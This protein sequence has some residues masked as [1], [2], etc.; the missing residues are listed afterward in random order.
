METAAPGPNPIEL[1][2][3]VGMADATT[4]DRGGARDAAPDP[5]TSEADG[6]LWSSSRRALT[7]GLVLNVTIVA[8]EALAV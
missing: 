6:G 2:H 3:P 7:L 5:H 4:E 1:G 8:S